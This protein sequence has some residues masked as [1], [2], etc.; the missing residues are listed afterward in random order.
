MVAS[1]R[2]VIDLLW[3]FQPRAGTVDSQLGLVP[4]A[5]HADRLVPADRG[6]PALG[7]L[8]PQKLAATDEP[9]CWHYAW[10]TSCS[11][12]SRAA[13]PRVCMVGGV[14][15]EWLRHIFGFAM[16]WG[17]LALLSSLAGDYLVHL[18]RRK[19][20]RI[21]QVSRAR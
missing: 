8:G 21:R 2:A 4:M 15:H 1:L 11:G 6:D 9:A 7:P 17:R 20:P 19:R 16:S 3:L 12:S 10:P 18:G 5:R 13:M 14:G